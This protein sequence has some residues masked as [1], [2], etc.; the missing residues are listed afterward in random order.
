MYDRGQQASQQAQ[1]QHEQQVAAY[2]QAAQ[3]FNQVSAAGQNPGPRPQQPGAFTDPGS[4]LRQQAQEMLD[5]ARQQRDSAGQQAQAAV[6]EA[7]G[8]APQT[9][10]FSQRML[11]DASDSLT[12]T[13]SAGEHVLGGVLKGAGGIV[14][15]ARTLNPMDPYNMTHPAEY[16]GGLSNT[17]AGLVHSVMHP[18]ELV[19]G[20]VG[21]GWGK[22][23]AE[24]FGKLLPNIALS[25]ATDGAGTAASA[26]EDVAE[27]EA[28]SAGEKA[29]SHDWSGLAQPTAHVSE[30]AI[31]AGSV[32]PAVEQQFI[33]DQHPWLPDVNGGQ[34][35]SHTPGYT[36]NCSENVIAVN[37]RLDGIDAKAAPLENPRW[38]DPARLGNPNAQFHDVP[39]YDHIIRDMNAQGEGARGV[40]YVG[41]A[42]GTAHVFNAIRG[43]DGVEFLD[44]QTGRLA[45][46]EPGVRIKYMPYR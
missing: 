34:Y 31:H 16:V 3:S 30:P 6:G 44:G 38:P 9:P 1:A 5:R 24:A 19:K 33:R 37:Q 29:A 23:P 36:Q 35:H 28:L 13:A 40:V 45:N 7:T 26:G 22:D 12:V 42:D 41:R 39:S 4:A 14:K 15:F 8:R 46:L 21:S 11:D 27:R 25:A 32:D 20:L 18:T 2:N 43:P 17:A 10:S